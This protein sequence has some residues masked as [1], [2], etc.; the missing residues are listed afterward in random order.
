[1]YGGDNISI[2]SI[3]HYLNSVNNLSILDQK[4]VELLKGEINEWE[5]KNAMDNMKLN[6]S[7]GSDGNPIEFYRS[8]WDDIKSVLIESINSAYQVGELSVSQKKEF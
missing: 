2:T 8:F 5:C 6:K 4:D 1:M 3:T 7:P